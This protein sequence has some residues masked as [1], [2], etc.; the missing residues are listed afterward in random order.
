MKKCLLVFLVIFTTICCF[1]QETDTLT[2]AETHHEK[3]GRTD[4]FV[5]RPQISFSTLGMENSNDFFSELDVTVAYRLSG[6]LTIGVKTGVS[7]W[8]NIEEFDE[9]ATILSL[10]LCLNIR[11]Y[12]F[13]RVWSPYMELS[14]GYCFKLNDPT[15]DLLPY[16]QIDPNYIY[17]Y[18]TVYYFS[19]GAI[20][21]FSLGLQY[22]NID[23]SLS[24][25]NVPFYRLSRQKCNFLGN[26][27]GPQ[28][29]YSSRDD[30]RFW[31]MINLSYNFL[32][33]RNTSTH[34][35]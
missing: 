3:S 35:L 32:L 23:C 24:I 16:Y 22:K 20:W 14:G 19:R 4:G 6:R 28:E 33:N 9:K 29:Y 1:A 31:I 27:M 2:S 12:I 17:D 13:D 15:I 10:P 34:G 5:I 25:K 7:D 11:H 18:Y 8:N 26:D 30:K 21:D